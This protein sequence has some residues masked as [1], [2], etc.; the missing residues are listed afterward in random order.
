MDKKRLCRLIDEG[1]EELFELLC[2]LIRIDSQSFNSWGKE[3]ELA[4]YLHGLA[5]QMGLESD[6]YSPLELEDFTEAGD[7][8]PGR[9]LEDRLNVTMR[10]RGESEEPGLMLMAHTDTVEVGDPANWTVDPLGGTIKDGKIYGRG[11]SEGA[12]V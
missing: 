4:E 12:H 1:R 8:F 10:L 9:G 5:Q 6:L 2:K 3:R 11:R 7:Y